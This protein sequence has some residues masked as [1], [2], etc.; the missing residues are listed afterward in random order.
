MDILFASDVSI[1]DVIGGAERVL[2][3]QSTRLQNK[4]HNV[5]ILTRKLPNHNSSKELIHRVQ[6][7]RYNVDQRNSLSFLRS[8]LSNCKELFESIQNQYTF[9]CINFHQPFSALAVRRSAA[10]RNIR[11]I[12]TCHSLSFEEFETRNPKPKGGGPE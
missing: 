4:G 11:K 9:D 1:H 12:Y 6:E 10:A 8:T 7:W 5:H 3:E 2:F